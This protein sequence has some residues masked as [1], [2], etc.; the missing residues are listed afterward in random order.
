[1]RPQRIAAEY[2]DGGPVDVLAAIRFNEAAANRC[3]IHCGPASCRSGPAC[4]NEAAANRCGIRR[5]AARIP[6]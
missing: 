1:M 2:K 6:A 5:K 4:F 3:G